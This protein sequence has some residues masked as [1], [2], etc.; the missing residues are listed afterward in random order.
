MPTERKNGGRY[1]REAFCPFFRGIKGK[2]TIQCEG[3]IHKT[4]I[5]LTFKSEAARSSYFNKYC[6]E[7]ACAEC[8]VYQAANEK[9]EEE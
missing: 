6:S 3:P 1:E 4:W 9:Y 5:S 8:R 7:K 2:S